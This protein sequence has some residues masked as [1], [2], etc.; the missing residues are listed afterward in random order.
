[1]GSNNTVY[2][3]RESIDAVEKI[4]NRCCINKKHEG[5]LLLS[6]RTGQHRKALVITNPEKE[7]LTEKI[8][9]P[10]GCSVLDLLGCEVTMSE[11]YAVITV[12]PLDVRVLIV[13]KP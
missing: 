1:M 12:E 4:F 3:E 8:A 9:L 10:A 11:G 7:R 6:E 2:I 5:R 13:S